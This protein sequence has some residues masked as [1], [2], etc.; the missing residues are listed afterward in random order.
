MVI[1][2]A[3]VN[4]QGVRRKYQFEKRMTREFSTEIAFCCTKTTTSVSMIKWDS[5][6][7]CKAIRKIHIDASCNAIKPILF[8][9]TQTK[10]RNTRLKKIAEF[11]QP[12]EAA[13]FLAIILITFR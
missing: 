4:K 2:Y 6:Q 1:L 12:S 8:T 7:E 11:I 3:Y 10:Q 5:H 9:R 13:R